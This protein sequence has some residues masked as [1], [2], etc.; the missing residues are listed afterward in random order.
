M[1]VTAASELPPPRPRPIGMFFLDGF[2]HSPSIPASR[3]YARTARTTRF[4]SS[5]GVP[6]AENSNRAAGSSMDLVAPVDGL[7]DR[8]DLVVAVVPTAEDSQIQIN[9]RERSQQHRV[10]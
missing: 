7:K 10:G 2:E 9:F 8:S 1:N 5:S 6:G 3:S 4:V